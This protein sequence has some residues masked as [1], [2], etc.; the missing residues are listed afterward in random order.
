[1]DKWTILCDCKEKLLFLQGLSPFLNRAL[2][3][4]IRFNRPKYDDFAYRSFLLADIVGD[5]SHNCIMCE[6][7]IN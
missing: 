7:R 1:M 2:I 5:A 4:R 3:A 6:I